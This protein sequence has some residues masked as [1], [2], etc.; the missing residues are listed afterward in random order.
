M[1]GSP[2]NLKITYLTN[3]RVYL[4]LNA[5]LSTIFS[6]V[7]L[8]IALSVLGLDGRGK[9]L[10]VMTYSSLVCNII[11]FGL[12]QG[13]LSAFRLAR[14]DA[15]RSNKILR[16]FVALTVWQ[17]FG[18]GLVV[19]VITNMFMYDWVIE[20]SASSF[21]LSFYCGSFLFSSAFVFYASMVS[22]GRF[23][24]EYTVIYYSVLFFSLYLIDL[25]FAVSVEYMIFAMSG[26]MWL[27][28][29]FIFVRVKIPIAFVAGRKEA[30]MLLRNGGKLVVWSNF[31]DLMYKID[32]LLL[33]AVLS[34]QNFGLYSVIQTLSQSIWRITDPLL[35][36]YQREMTLGKGGQVRVSWVLC[37]LSFTSI[38]IYGS[39]SIWAVSIF[40][41]DSLGDLG[42][43]IFLLGAMNLM[44]A[45]WKLKAVEFVVF[46]KN[47]FMDATISMFLIIYIGCYSFVSSVSEALILSISVYG[48]MVVAALLLPRKG[49]S[50]V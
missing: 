25:F 37:L 13:S 39:V 19:L 6:L 24:F 22:P 8:K 4:G 40:V 47:L 45:Y 30:L 15:K 43:L 3:D 29:A 14:D 41:D 18:T 2:L 33:P 32:I 38:V 5:A 9:L 11:R 36:I 20:L 7:L 16:S 34:A 28:I 12:N 27:G 42:L 35:G 48:L 50:V 44:F 26:S 21:A 31:K 10:I 46:G 1:K 17:S 49:S 23:S